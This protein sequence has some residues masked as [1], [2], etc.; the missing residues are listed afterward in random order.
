MS[1]G[2]Q[3]SSLPFSREQEQNRCLLLLVLLLLLLVSAA[4]S[5]CLISWVW[6]ALP[7]MKRSMEK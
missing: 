6:E 7:T 5:A 3:K 1:T 2:C 4:V